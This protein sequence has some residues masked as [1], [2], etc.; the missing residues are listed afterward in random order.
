MICRYYIGNGKACHFITIERWRTGNL[1]RSLIDH[2][3]LNCMADSYRIPPTTAI[4]HVHLKVA[5][6]ERSLR[7]YRDL[8]GFEVT[9]RYGEQAVFLSAGGYHHH[10]GLNT[11]ESKGGTRPPVGYTGLYH[12]AILLPSRQDLA[13]LVKR[14]MDAQYPLQ[15]ASDH[16]VSEAVYLEDPDGNGIE[17]YRDRPREEWSYQD[18]GSLAM[19]TGFLD[20]DE[21]V[22]SGGREGDSAG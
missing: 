19:T 3:R 9:A 4:G 20:L 18:D 12:V 11:W 16:G 21:L 14:L 10:I 17:L 1:L 22:S 7:F 8:L 15:G 6:L 5:D 13:R 2:P